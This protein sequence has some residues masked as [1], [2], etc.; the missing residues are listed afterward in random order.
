VRESCTKRVRN[1]YKAFR[2]AFRV[3]RAAFRVNRVA[4]RANRVAFRVNRA[5]FRA[6]RVAFVQRAC[7]VVARL[8]VCIK[9]VF[10]KKMCSKNFRHLIL[11]LIFVTNNRNFHSSEYRLVNFSVA[12]NTSELRFFPQFQTQKGGCVFYIN[13]YYTRPNTVYISM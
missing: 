8:R 5:A 13:A 7:G 6:N 11:A 4:F 1:V 9:C 2:A 3:N 12:Y 10:K